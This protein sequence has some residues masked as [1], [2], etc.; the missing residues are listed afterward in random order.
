M[1]VWTASASVFVL[2]LAWSS[3]ALAQS[4]AAPAG[5]ASAAS[6]EK[7]AATTAK[8]SRDTGASV[9]EVIVTA[10][11]RE[12]NVQ[13]VPIV[14]NSVDAVRAQRR[15]V[16]SLVDLPTIAP[17]LQYN[18]STNTGLVFMRGVG[19]GTGVAGAEGPMAFYL[20]DVYVY[21]LNANMFQLN[22]ISRVEVLSGPQ[23]TLFGRNALA[24]V[25]QV[26]TK[27]PGQQAGLDA[28]VGYG[29]YQTAKADIYASTP[30][31]DRLA[32]DIA[33]LGVDQMKGF[34]T[35]IKTGKDVFYTQDFTVRSKLRWDPTDKTSAVFSLMFD[36]S[37]NDVGVSSRLLPGSIGRDRTIAPQGYYDVNQELQSFF[38]NTAYMASFALNHDL[39]WADIKNVVAYQ[40]NHNL[41]VYDIDETPSFI[42]E[43][44]PVKLFSKT[45]T[46]ELQLASKSTGWVTWIGGLF[47]L[48]NESGYDPSRI[49]GNPPSALNG[50]YFDIVSNLDTTSISGYG[51]VT[52]K[53]TDDT[54]V[55]GGLRYTDDRRHV[56][57]K[58]IGQTGAISGAGDQTHSWSQVTYRVSVDHDFASNVLGYVAYNRGFKAG[59][60]NSASPADPGVLPETIDDYEV[61]LK[62][63]PFDRKLR[64]NVA[65]FYY[66]YENIQLRQVTAS[67]LLRLINA[68]SARNYGVDLSFETAA[69]HGFRLQGAAEWLDAKFTD[70]P[71]APATQRAPAGGVGN[72]TV[73]TNYSGRDMLFA[74]KFTAS[75]GAQ[76]EWTSEVGDFALGANYQYNDGFDW[77][78]E[79]DSRT[80]QK[81]Y[82]LL[83]ANLTWTSHSQMLSAR[84]WGKNITGEKYLTFVNTSAN[85]DY[86]SPADPATFGV[87]LGVKFR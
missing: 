16:E 35:N 64:L 26:F 36:R 83:N 18:R 10:Q 39:G 58:N 22:N 67:S 28:H 73:T 72:I 2:S 40:D 29:S 34:G 86:G 70:F 87:T 59:T 80:H 4:T 24:G 76:Y 21:A 63:E 55:T 9:D 57:G 20:D 31:N 25:V 60:F 3:A 8:S 85:G 79:V 7:P 47:F 66:N 14:V 53:L 81:P 27:D 46:E 15:G 13:Q 65:A 12:E 38:I 23:G 45:W 69:Y 19:Q 41:E 49:Q 33:A 75:L 44:N 5:G 32:I 56:Y 51:Q 30:I 48:R 37:R 84:L 71:G 77:S 6:A 61:G 54:R 52:A 68:A 74:P 50:Q 43:Q 82:G 1:K 78:I 42:S 62:S 11:K 17:G